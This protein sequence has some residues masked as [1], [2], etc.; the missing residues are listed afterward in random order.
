MDQ[1]PPSTS[2]CRNAGAVLGTVAR[3]M[4]LLNV[5]LVAG[6]ALGL[7]MGRD[8]NSGSQAPPVLP[9]C[10]ACKGRL[11]HGLYAQNVTSDLTV[12]GVTV[13]VQFFVSH[14][15]H[16]N[17]TATMHLVPIKAPSFPGHPSSSGA[18]TCSEMPVAVNETTCE[19]SIENDCTRAA[20]KRNSVSEMQYVWD[21]GSTIRVYETLSTPLFKRV[22]TW[23]E[24]PAEP[25][26]P[27]LQAGVAGTPIAV[28][29]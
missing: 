15:F 8:L 19:I 4:C 9:T 25:S 22:F 14:E 6:G 21:G 2:F 12:L 7:L 10:G 20:N 23:D 18:Y 16:P 5:G 1:S 27:L 29:I 13:N 11:P 3:R 24:H 28:H 26:P 17:G